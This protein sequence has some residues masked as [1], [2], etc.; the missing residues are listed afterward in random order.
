MKKALLIG[1]FNGGLETP[2]GQ[3]IKSQQLLRG[4]SET[5]RF[6]IE[7]IDV[8][9]AKLGTIARLILSFRAT[10]HIFVLPGKR[11]LLTAGLVIRVL[12]LIFPGSTKV[13]LVVVGGWLRK[14]KAVAIYRFASRAFDT[15]S[16]EVKSIC[17]NL[18]ATTTKVL[19]LVNFRLDTP[20]DNLPG[21]PVTDAL[22]IVFLSRVSREKGVF[23]A[24]AVA[25]ALTLLRVRC[26]L[27]IYGPLEFSCASDFEEFAQRCSQ[28]AGRMSYLGKKNNSEVVPLLATYH[29]LLFPSVYPGEGFPGVIAEAM[30]ADLAV[31]TSDHGVLRELNDDFSFGSVA[32]G[33]FV[34]QATKLLRGGF[35]AEWQRSSEARKAASPRTSFGRQALERWL[36]EIEKVE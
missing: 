10:D 23:D 34:F 5:G 3:V 24:L 28:S 26:S 2:N 7:V 33:D 21:L 20:P 9:V 36:A 19:E 14:K 27:D 29:C 15:I 32:E 16:P 1:N 18:E 11:L 30:L 6:A 25:E 8:S 31:I 17:A 4:I 22:R 12:R 13:H 35:L